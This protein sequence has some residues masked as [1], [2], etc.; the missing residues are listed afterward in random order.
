MPAVETEAGTTTEE[1]WVKLKDR[2]AED[3]RGGVWHNK[4]SP[5]VM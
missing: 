2:F 1:I 4:A 3:N 5:M